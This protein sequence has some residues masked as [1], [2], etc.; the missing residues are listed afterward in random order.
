[1]LAKVSF[2]DFY[3]YYYYNIY[4]QICQAHVN[5]FLSEKKKENLGTGMEMLLLREGYTYVVKY[6]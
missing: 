6:K 4:F 3:T 1:M 5:D 2:V